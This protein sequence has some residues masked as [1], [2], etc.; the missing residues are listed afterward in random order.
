M[1]QLQRFLN[2]TAEKVS[3]PQGSRESFEHS[4]G[5]NCQQKSREPRKATAGEEEAHRDLLLAWMPSAPFIPSPFEPTDCPS[6]ISLL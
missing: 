2:R 3:T 1:Q 4:K 6:R 5:T